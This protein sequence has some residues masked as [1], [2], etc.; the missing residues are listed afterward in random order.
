LQI[1]LTILVSIGD[2]EICGQLVQAGVSL[3]GPSL[4][5]GKVFGLAGSETSFT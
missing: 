3:A 1:R 5:S 2:S 4:N